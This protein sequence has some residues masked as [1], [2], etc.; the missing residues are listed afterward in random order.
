MASARWLWVQLPKS[1]PAWGGTRWLRGRDP[2]T[3]GSPDTHPGMALSLAHAAGT[4]PDSTHHGSC[5][6]GS[7]AVGKEP[8]HT[9]GRAVVMHPSSWLLPCPRVLSDSVLVTRKALDKCLFVDERIRVESCS[10]PSCAAASP[11]RL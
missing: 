3:V 4:L 7:R 11:S 9:G 1:P 10:A 8:Q 5:D 6:G 2:G